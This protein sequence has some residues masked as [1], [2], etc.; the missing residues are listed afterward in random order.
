MT[1]NNTQLI[2]PGFFH[3]CFKA[4]GMKQIKVVITHSKCVA[5]Q[6]A[7]SGKKLTLSFADRP[8]L[9]YEII[10]KFLKK[11]LQNIYNNGNQEF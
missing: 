10:Q 3:H 2:L 8:T 11:R 6:V 9:K 7:T 5:E 4:H 1:G